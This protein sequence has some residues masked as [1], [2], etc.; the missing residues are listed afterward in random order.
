MK[1]RPSI[2]LY[3]SDCLDGFCS[4]WVAWKKFGIH[5]SYYAVSP[6]QLPFPISK[7]RNTE[8]YVVDNSL[9]KKDIQTLQAQGCAVIILDH[10]KSSE[11]DVKNADVY[12]FDTKHS[13][14]MLAW[15]YFF[16]QQ[17]APWLVKYVEDG[18]LWNFKLAHTD[19]IRNML[20]LKGFHLKQ[21]NLFARALEDPL[22]K[23]TLIA[24]GEIVEQYRRTLIGQSTQ[25]A[26]LVKFAGHTVYAVNEATQSIRSEVAH[27]LY[28]K[29]PPFSIVWS[30]E[31]DMISVSLRSDGKFDVSKLAQKY[32]G[33]GHPVASGF[34]FPAKNPFPWHIVKTTQKG[35]Y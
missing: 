33:G 9:S 11:A 21:W 8:V 6:R 17:K 5:A 1:K 34:T 20:V 31:G 29:K 22:K 28:K 30:L 12:V 15:K 19:Q 7:I 10:H 16:P 18:D 2:V 26:Y 24:Q 27:L 14:A 32:G 13:G 25:K 4:F 35:V 23:R 3:H